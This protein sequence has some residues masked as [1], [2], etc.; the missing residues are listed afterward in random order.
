VAAKPDSVLTL[1]ASTNAL[2]A[3]NQTV[4]FNLSS[5]PKNIVENTK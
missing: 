1:K 5:Y 4:D 2:T 3:V